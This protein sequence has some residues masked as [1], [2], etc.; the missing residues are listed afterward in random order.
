MRI[1]PLALA[2]GLALAAPAFADEATDLAR[3]YAEMPAVQ[4]MFD[5]VFSPEAMAQQF[6]AGLPADMTIS[7]D[8]L[9]RV[10]GILSGMLDKL[11]PQLTEIMISSMA[12]QFSP[13]EI[14]ALIDFYASEHGAAVMRK[15]QPYMQDVMAQFMPLMQAEQQ[16]VLPQIIDIMKE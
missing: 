8:Q 9:A 10:G 1:L 2:A 3:Q 11:R 6:R 7:D 5:D 16:Q 4:G 13:A 14:S 15:M 12:S